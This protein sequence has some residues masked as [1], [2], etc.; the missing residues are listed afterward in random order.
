MNPKGL[1]YMENKYKKKE[2]G[3]Q[4]FKCVDYSVKRRGVL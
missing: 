3:R 4:I 1:F 2:N